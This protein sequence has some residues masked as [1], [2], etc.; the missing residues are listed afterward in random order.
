[1]KRFSRFNEYK[2]LFY[3]ILLVYIFYFIARILFYFYNVNLIKINSFYDFIRLSYHGIAFDTTT[4][5][6]TNILFIVLSV[7]P[8][9]INTKKVFQKI[10]FY[11]YF[12]TNLLMYSFNFVDFIYYRY[13]FNRSTRA[14]LDTLENEE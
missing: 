3:R 1:M 9:V 11:L 6:Y 5:L 12:T 2:V 14:S 10:L 8:L 4:I 7:L 13:S